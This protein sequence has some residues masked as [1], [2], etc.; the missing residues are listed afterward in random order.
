M[1]RRIFIQLSV[2]LLHFLPYNSVFSILQFLGN[3]LHSTLDEDGPSSSPICY[4]N[5][6]IIPRLAR[7]NTLNMICPVNIIHPRTVVFEI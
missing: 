3:F 7:K 1:L 5:V 6:F 4:T 2:E